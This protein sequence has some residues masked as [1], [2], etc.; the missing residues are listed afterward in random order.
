MKIFSKIA[1]PNS[2]NF[3]SGWVLV[4]LG[5]VLPKCYLWSL[6]GVFDTPFARFETAF[7]N[8]FL[9]FHFNSEF[10]IL[11]NWLLLSSLLIWLGL[12]KIYHRPLVVPVDKHHCGLCLCF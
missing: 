2:T 4:A 11:V 8:F 5:L 7:Q 10:S 6:A 1:I 12:F 3:P 9:F